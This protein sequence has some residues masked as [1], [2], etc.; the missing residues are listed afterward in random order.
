MN[1]LRIQGLFYFYYFGWVKVSI[2]LKLPWHFLISLDELY[3][4]V[5]VCS[6]SF[7]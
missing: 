1:L 6:S 2:D 4:A 5:T 3:G 7:N